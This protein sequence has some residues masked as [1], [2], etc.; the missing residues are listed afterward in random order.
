MQ[1]FEQLGLSAAL[2]KNLTQMGFLMPTPIQEKTIPFLIKEQK[3]LLA[4][5]QTGTGKTAAF[6]LPLIELCDAQ[7]SSTQALVL[8][9]TRELCVQIMNDLV[10]FSQG[11]KNLNIVAVYGGASISDQVRQLKRGAQIVVATPG[12]LMDL[13]ERKAV[14]IVNLKFAVLDEADEMLNMGFE[15]DIKTILKD[16]PPEKNVWLFS[17]T[18]PAEIRRIASKYMNKPMELSVSKENFSNVN[19]TH[20]FAV[21]AERERYAALKRIIDYNLDIFGL[22]FCRTKADTQSVAEKLIQDGYNADALHGDLSQQQRDKVMRS[23]RNKALQILV[24]TDVAARGIDVDNITH[25]LHLNLPDEMEFYTHRSGRTARAGK[26]GTS[27]AL[28]TMKEAFKI[29]QIEKSIQVKFERI[30]IPSGEEVC[31]RKV[32]HLVHRLREVDTADDALQSMI[33][34]VIEEL[35]DLTKEDIITRFAYLEFN[36]LLDYYRGAPDLNQAEKREDFRPKRF[37]REDNFRSGDR[38]RG[39]RGGDRSRHESASM[40]TKLFINLG[41]ADGLDKGKL[42]GLVCDRSRIKKYSIGRI[43]LKGVYS[44]LEVEPK[45]VDAVLKQLNGFDFKGRMIRIEVQGTEKRP[46]PRGR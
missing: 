42:L 30:K 21:V 18:M 33:P 40:G 9:P 11:V 1:T 36:H 26:L 31:E 5:A 12:R 37:E 22:V 44:F 4:M 10:K 28:V 41:K 24:A 15:E 3:D 32:L 29:K 38:E 2:L 46:A 23:F 34:A 39:D 7:S 17:A 14:N 35:K 43:E 20:Q 19:I 8:A 25:V 45:A 6:G 27:I 13:M 16:T